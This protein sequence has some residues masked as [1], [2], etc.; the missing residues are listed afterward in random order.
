[1]RIGLKDGIQLMAFGNTDDYNNRA[2][3]DAGKTLVPRA[4]ILF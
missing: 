1:M 3:L 4:G 2:R